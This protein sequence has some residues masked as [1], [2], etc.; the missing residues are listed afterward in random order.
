MV[1]E[2][3]IS[4]RV[5]LPQHLTCEAA[6][7]LPHLPPHRDCFHHRG[8]LYEH[9]SEL[10]TKKLSTKTERQGSQAQVLLAAL[11]GQTPANQ[12][13]GQDR[14][15]GGALS[16]SAFGRREPQGPH[17]V[18]P[19]IEAIAHPSGMHTTDATGPAH[20]L[21][22]VEKN[23]VGLNGIEHGH[24]PTCG[25]VSLLTPRFI[26][27]SYMYDLRMELC[28]HDTGPVGTFPFGGRL[29]P[30]LVRHKGLTCGLA[31]GRHWP[32]LEDG[33][34]VGQLVPHRCLWGWGAVRAA[35][36]LTL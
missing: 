26:A 28:Q 34:A 21:S 30:S 9:R 12:A 11:I 16:H 19:G 23:C 14:D 5:C 7:R 25:F 18:G 22:R 35:N 31:E 8:L 36:L 13:G 29:M 3:R 1:T 27:Q 17:S 33:H 2:K 24:L 10:V 4:Q 6:S 32:R 20:K 15:D